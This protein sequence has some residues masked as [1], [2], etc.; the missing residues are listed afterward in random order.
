MVA[1][2]TQGQLSGPFPDYKML[3]IEFLILSNIFC[4]FDWPGGG[5]SESTISLLS[6]Y[7]D[8]SYMTFN[9]CY[10]FVVKNYIFQKFE[11]SASCLPS[12]DIDQC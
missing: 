4:F 5:G 7:P 6:Y 10:K 3:K 8:S 12:P 1:I 2:L 9:F 11:C